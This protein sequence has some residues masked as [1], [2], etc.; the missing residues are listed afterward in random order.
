MFF[1][2]FLFRH[3]R[4]IHEYFTDAVRIYALSGD[5]DARCAVIVAAKVAGKKQRQSMVESLSKMAGNVRRKPSERVAGKSIAER[6]LGLMREVN[7]KD[8]GRKGL[9][10][11]EMFSKM[12][13]E[14]LSCL[15]RG[16]PSIF[17]R[18]YPGLF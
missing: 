14:Y 7:F 9:G 16:D 12:N 11:E 8:G 4:G 15:N 3:S 17:K 10:G 2:N 1:R 5:E 18:K 13:G 6:I